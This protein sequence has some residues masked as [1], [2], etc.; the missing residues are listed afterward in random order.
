MIS[1]KVKSELIH[2]ARSFNKGENLFD[3]ANIVLE[4]LRILLEE[5]FPIEEYIKHRLDNEEN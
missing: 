1:Q 3:L 4:S 5:G 2:R